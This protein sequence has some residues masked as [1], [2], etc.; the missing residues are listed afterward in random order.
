MV[1]LLNALH[2][3][4]SRI[5]DQNSTIAA[6]LA[7]YVN[8]L[9]RR[10]IAGQKRSLQQSPTA[11]SAEDSFYKRLY[12]NAK[13]MRTVLF[14]S[15]LTFSTQQHT[16]LDMPMSIKESTISHTA[17][18]VVNEINNGEYY[19]KN[20]Q[21]SKLIKE[22]STILDLGTNVGTT[23]ITMAKM[24]PQA[25]VIGVEP[26]PPNFACA[27]ENVEKN[28]VSDRVTVLNAALSSDVSSLLTQAPIPVALLF[29]QSSKRADTATNS[30]F[31]SSQWRKSST[32]SV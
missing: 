7:S 32:I 22:G 14:E 25:R 17:E 20:V 11:A 9:E 24:F 12:E 4:G 1:V 15:A 28:G 21:E 13:Q 30:P 6:N 23:A 3:Q 8:T 16:V 26:M 19:L 27:L 2:L 10:E 31:I 5:I 18:W 29:L